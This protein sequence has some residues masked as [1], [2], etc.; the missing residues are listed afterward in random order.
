MSMSTAFILKSEE[1]PALPTEYL[2]PRW[3]AAYTRANH[4]K[5]V[6]EQLGLRG[7]ESFLPLY[8]SVRRWKDRR[9]QLRL[10]LFP[11]YVFVRVALSG[12]L[13]VLQIRSVARLVRFNGYPVVLPET[14]IENLRNGLGSKLLIEPHPYLTSGRRVRVISGPLRGSEGILLRL[15]NNFRVVLSIDVLM[16][17]V[18]AEVDVA[19]LDLSPLK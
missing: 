12:R 19:D 14:D 13:R 5:R 4:E 16:R 8:E 6:A 10:P 18:A 15:K 17:S 1:Y 7:I 11:G 9:V 3:Y 2:E